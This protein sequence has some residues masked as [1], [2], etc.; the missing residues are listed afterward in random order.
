MRESYD[1]KH[2]NEG[3]SRKKVN[4]IFVYYY[5]SNGETIPKKD[6]ERI[7]KLKIPPAWTELW[8]SRDVNATIQAIGKDIKGRKQYKYHQV[9]IEKAEQEKFLRLQK[10]IKAIPRLDKVIHEHSQFDMYN[11]YKV[12]SLMLQLVKEYHMRVG[13]EVYA[14]TNRSYGISSLRKKHIKSSKGVI[15]FRFKGK[16]NKRLHYTIRNDNF[17]SDIRLLMKLDGDHLFQYMQQ[18]QFGYTKVYPVNDKDLN[19]YIQEHMGNDFSI[20]D[21]RTYAANHH[22]IRSLL[23]ETI[24]RTPKDRKTIKKNLVAAFKSTAHQ[25]KH[26]LAISKKS[27]VISFAIELYQNEPDLFVSHK[28]DDPDQMMMFLLNMYRKEVLDI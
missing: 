19:V 20:K 24:K 12:I 8:I 26:T 21:F 16:S 7:N 10:F 23:G 17:I 22:F 15:Y 1:E 13:K 27:Y 11:K 14:R 28:Y 25:L 9:H 3:I 5:I 6:M 18:D 2:W 4:N